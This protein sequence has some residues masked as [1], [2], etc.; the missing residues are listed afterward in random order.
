MLSVDKSVDFPQLLFLVLLSL[1]FTECYP[2]SWV[3]VCSPLWGY[4]GM[5][6]AWYG[7]ERLLKEL[8]KKA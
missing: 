7:V 4:W 5:I 3:W 6:V 8:C 2:Y 1:K